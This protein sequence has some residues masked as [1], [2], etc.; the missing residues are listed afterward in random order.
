MEFGGSSG[1][2]VRN[3]RRSEEGVEEKGREKGGGATVEGV[4]VRGG[5]GKKEGREK[6]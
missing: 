1:G 2:E 5:E 6:G 3:R 4:F